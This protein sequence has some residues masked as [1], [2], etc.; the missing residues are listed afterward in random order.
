VEII[1]HIGTHKTGT[2]AVQYF[3]QLNRE[4]LAKKGIHYAC[5]ARSKN[6][7]GLG[8]LVAK[9]HSVPVREFVARHAEEAHQKGANRILISAE[10]LFAMSTFF[11][12][13]NGRCSD[14]WKLESAAIDL[15]RGVMPQDTPIKLIVFF[16]RQDT[17]LESIYCQMLSEDR[18]FTMNIKEFYV[19]MREALDYHEHLSMWSTV[20][21]DFTVRTYEEAS[22]NVVDFFLRTALEVNDFAEFKSADEGARW[23]VAR[24]NRDVIEYKMLLDRG[25]ATSIDRTMN[26]FSCARLAKMFSYDRKN[27]D[28]LSLPERE[29][30]LHDFRLSNQLLIE[31]FGMTPFPVI[32]N[33]VKNWTPYPGLSQ[34]KLMEL[35][36]LDAQIRRTPTYR[37][38][39]FTLLL[40]HFIVT[41]LKFS[42]WLVLPLGRFIL[43]G[44]KRRKLAE[45]YGSKIYRP[46]AAVA[47]GHPEP[48]YN[49]GDDRAPRKRQ[50][51]APR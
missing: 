18:K 31:K 15:F 29:A 20:F 10:S 24:W 40:R 9:G 44:H 8:P 13:L 34:K 16:R 26:A 3:L 12:K 45:K 32:A 43:R 50:L 39:R 30:L 2:S 17:F 22:K 36:E 6:A 23:V 33:Y 38:E 7:N 5:F 46:R 21:P 27:Q 19:F 49:A 47:V 51:S 1:L 11:H 14:Y 42:A 48:F 28:Y 25:V 4:V 35:R 37:I 41:R